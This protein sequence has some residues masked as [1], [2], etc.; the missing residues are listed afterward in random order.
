MLGTA[1]ASV[2][3]ALAG[4]DDVLQSKDVPQST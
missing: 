3:L 2:E 4:E 1:G